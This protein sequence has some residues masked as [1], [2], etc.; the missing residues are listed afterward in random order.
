MSKVVLN[1]KT[2]ADVKERAQ[3]IARQLGVPLSLVVNA[4]LKEFI[5][6]QKLSLSMTPQIRPE[7]GKLLRQA[8]ADHAA[9]KNISDTFNN[10]ASAL[11]YLHS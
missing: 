4:Y 1:V 5:R 10:S 7:V 3:Q 8:S 11:E 9:G 6:E 2:D